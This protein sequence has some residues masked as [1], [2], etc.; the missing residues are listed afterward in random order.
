M[1][2]IWCHLNALANGSCHICTT[3]HTWMGNV[4]NTISSCHIYDAI[5]MHWRMGNGFSLI[6]K[7][8][9]MNGYCLMPQTEEKE[10]KII[11]TAKISTSFHGNP[12]VF[13]TSFHGRPQNFIIVFQ[14]KRN[15]RHSKDLSEKLTDLEI[16]ILLVW[17]PPWAACTTSHMNGSLHKYGF[18]MS[19][20]WYHLNTLA[21]GSCH[22]CTTSHMNVSCH[23]YMHS[24]SQKYDAT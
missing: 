16:K 24:S 7:T 20:A 11:T 8:P 5:L 17:S 10:L 18:F 19:H 23:K 15:P 4:T 21:S 14:S 6:C 1:S 22:I 2:Q 13:Q 12:C 9:H 3:P